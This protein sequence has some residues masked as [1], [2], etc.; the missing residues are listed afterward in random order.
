MLITIV[1]SL[2]IY[3][4]SYWGW[5]DPDKNAVANRKKIKIFIIISIILFPLALF[6]PS[7]ETLV[8]MYIARLATGS[9]VELVIQKI[10]DVAKE[11]K[12]F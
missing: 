5:N 12:G 10:I 11:I 9:N 1:C 2:F 4:E 8:K 7:G 6:L 3:H